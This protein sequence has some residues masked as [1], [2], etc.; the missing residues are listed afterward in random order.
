MKQRIAVLA[1]G[2][3]VWDPRDLVVRSDW[4]KDGP[5][6]PIEFA[7]ISNDGRLTL[8]IKPGFRPVQVFHAESG[9]TSLEEARENLQE[10]EGTVLDRIGFLDFQSGRHSIR[11]WKSQMIQELTLWGEDKGYDAVIWTDIGPRF[12]DRI[13][14]PFSFPEIATYLNGLDGDTWQRAANYIIQTPAAI[15]TEYRR[16]LEDHV[17]QR[18]SQEPPVPED[19]LVQ[20][21]FFPLP[22]ERAVTLE[23]LPFIREYDGDDES[24]AQQGVAILV[25][26]Y[27]VRA[28]LHSIHT[29]SE[30]IYFKPDGDYPAHLPLLSEGYFQ[31]KHFH[32]ETPGVLEWGGGQPLRLQWP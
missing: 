24:F 2:S 8:V 31:T 23:D 22:V 30:R 16:A 20:P 13:H 17:R 12:T 29:W 25:D 7:R 6:L 32:M 1:W 5:K 28:L 14:R 9:L 19:S 3:L 10:R 18:L 27:P 4:F 21:P 11:R 26:G 15:K